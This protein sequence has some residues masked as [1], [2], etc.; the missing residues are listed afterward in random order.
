MSEGRS[1]R[2]TAPPQRSP[3]ARTPGRVRGALSL[4]VA[5]FLLWRLSGLGWSRVVSNLPH[6]PA[7]YAISF[8]IYL[9]LPLSEIMVY[10]CIL[11]LD[12]RGCLPAFL[13]KRVYNF[14]VFGYSGEAWFILWAQRHLGLPYRTVISAVKDNNI[15][16]G[17]VSNS[18]TVILLIAFLLSGHR[19][20]IL[21][22]VPGAAAWATGLCLAAVVLVPI[23]LRF[24]RS[25]LAVTPAKAGT[26]AVIHASRILLA[27]SLMALQWSIALPQ[28]PAATWLMF[29]A[30]QMLLT[31]IPFLPNQ[32]L[33][34]LA[35]G[36][37]LAGMV[38]APATA[39]AGMFLAAGALTQCIHLAVYAAT[40]FDQT[41]SRTAT[42]GRTLRVFTR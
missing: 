38:A 28:V 22:A 14:A 30:A 5:A 6:S 40:S 20:D 39:V 37:S 21:E 35:L 10:R 26:V 42:A 23:L 11:G 29:L 24:H 2:H 25:I 7:F 18:V 27:Q 1:R 31:R 8:V 19:D 4:A 15:L 13:R 3:W 36:L 17:L 41:L 12:L 33:V 32:D 16:S 9:L 34:V